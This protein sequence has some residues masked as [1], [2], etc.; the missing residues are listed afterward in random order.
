[1]VDGLPTW[2]TGV[3]QRLSIETVDGTR[4]TTTQV[5][6]LQTP[7]WYGDIRIPGN[8]PNLRAYSSLKELT[9]DDALALARQQGF[10]GTAALDNDVCQ[11][12][13]YID[14]QPP[15]TI[16]DIGRLSW[17]GDIMIEDG[18]DVAY[19][20]EWKRID[21]GDGDFTAIAISAPLNAAQ[22]YLASI[23][24]AGDIFIYTRARS[25]PLSTDSTLQDSLL[26][27]PDRFS[28][29]LDCEISYGVCRTGT[30]PWEIKLSTL[31]WRE[32]QSLWKIDTLSVDLAQGEVVQR[33]DGDQTVHARRWKIYHWGTGNVFKE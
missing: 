7:S 16:R 24:I 21:D 26:H 8:R 6:Y 17:Q 22:S 13:R 19:R 18:I 12:H 4:D 23:V 33:L 1:M 25:T 15:S 28:Q 29:Y 10:S 9:Y 5:F 2:L 31:P 27:D 20:E 32:G 30:V 3:W 14:Y 11:W